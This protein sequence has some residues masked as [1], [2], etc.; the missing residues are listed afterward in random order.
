MTLREFKNK[1]AEEYGY[2]DWYD[3]LNYCKSNGFDESEI[4]YDDITIEFTKYHIE[5][6]IKSILENGKIELSKDWLV[7][8]QTINGNSLVD[9]ITIK[10]NKE[11]RGVGFL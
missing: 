10:L 7:K 9:S 11:S 5:K 3:Y 1:K 6:C 4:G 8:E 2:E